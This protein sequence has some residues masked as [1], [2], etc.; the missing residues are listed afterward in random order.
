MKDKRFLKAGA[1]AD[2]ILKNTNIMGGNETIYIW[3]FRFFWFSF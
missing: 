2:H 1:P 3:K